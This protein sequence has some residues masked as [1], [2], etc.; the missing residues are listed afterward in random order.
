M[1]KTLLSATLF[2]FGVLSVSA[3]ITIT[4]ADVAIPTKIIYEETDT[5][6]IVSVG[7]PG[8]TTQTWNMSLL[9]SGKIDTLSFLNYS[10]IPNATFSS[11]NLVAKQG[12]TSNYAYMLNSA[13]GLFTLG[14]AATVD[15]GSGPKAVKQINSPSETRQVFPA[16]YATTDTNNFT[17]TTPAFLLGIT[18]SGIFIDSAR[19]KSVVQKTVIVDAW[20]SLTTPLGTYN[21]IRSKETKVNHDTTDAFSSTFGGIWVP[22]IQTAADSV[23]TYTWWANGIGFPIATA[24]MDSTGALKSV[25]W[26][27]SLPAT[28]GINELVSAVTVNVFPNPAENELNITIDGSKTVS[29]QVFDVS[30]RLIDTYAVENNYALINTT[31]Y[32]NGIYMYSI[33]GKE[34]TLLSRGKFTIAK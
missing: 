24:T 30:G 34:N 11:S 19:A 26:L 18:V 32:A 14:N 6:P 5:L 23:V 29:I 4:T 10:S 20:G 9:N 33:I 13:I 27:K 2:C 8:V 21:V 1:K 31:A 17:T 22:A 28:A 16:T 12:S 3:Q 15:F 25:Q 7:A